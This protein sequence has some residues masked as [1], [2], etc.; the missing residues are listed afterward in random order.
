MRTREA[1][2]A[3]TPHPPDAALQ[4]YGHVLSAEQVWLSRLTGTP[5][6]TAVWP[7]LTLPECERIGHEAHQRLAA[8]VERLQVADLTR[9]I[10]YVNSA[11][12][13]FQ[14]TIEDIVLHLCLHGAYHRG[15]VA[16]L[17]RTNGHVPSPTDYI[18]YTRGAPAATR[19]VEFPP[20]PA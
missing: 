16:Q 10:S 4:L 8:F 20:R 14:S 3:A 13:A 11:G 17:L 19:R 12:Q 15:Q 1:L 18:A 7:A 2:T 5:P 6:A 9:I